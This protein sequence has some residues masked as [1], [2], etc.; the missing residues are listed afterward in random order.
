MTRESFPYEPITDWSRAGRQRLVEARGALLRSLLDEAFSQAVDGGLSLASLRFHGDDPVAEAVA[1]CIRRFEAVDLDPARLPPGSRS[2]RL[3]TE[4]RFWV[5][6]REGAAGARRAT[7]SPRPE[8]PAPPRDTEDAADI[9]RERQRQCERVCAGLRTL[10]D[11]CC[12]ALVGWWLEGA[13]DLRK[14]LLAPH[15][16]PGSWPACDAARSP[17]ARSFHVADAL[18]RY[19]AMFAGLVRYAD[20]EPTHRACVLT[21]FSPA[22]TSRPTRSRAGVVRAALDDM[23]SRQ[24][25]T[26]RHEGVRVLIHRCTGHA[27]AAVGMDGG[28]DRHLARES[29]RASLLHRFKVDDAALSRRIKALAAGAP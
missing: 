10:R 4:V 15:D 17:K 21:W 12:A 1:W 16:P 25:T 23:P 29:L 2:L 5:A 20:D 22:A 8:P 3:F 7:R 14:A 28:L 19:Y 9:D 13:I 11:R 26:L 18:F 6:Q 27:E 24:M